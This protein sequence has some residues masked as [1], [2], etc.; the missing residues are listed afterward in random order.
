MNTTERNVARVIGT[1]WGEYEA[2]KGTMDP[3]YRAGQLDMLLTLDKA[4]QNAVC[5][6]NPELEP[7][8]YM[9]EVGLAQTERRP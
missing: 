8:R 5:S 7:D 2:R 1:A 3:Q 9:N 6:A 4:L